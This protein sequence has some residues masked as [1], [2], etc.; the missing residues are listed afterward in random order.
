MF[1][2]ALRNLFQEKT[3][4][5]ISV[6]GVAFSVTLIMVLAGLYQG[7][8]NKI[9]EYIRTVP[10]DIWVMQSGTEELFHTPSVLPLTVGDKLEEVEGVTDAKPFNARR[11]ALS[12]HNHDVNLYI[13]AYDS[14]NDIGKPARVIE[15]KDA[16]GPG[17]IIIDKSQSKKVA[18]G[19]SIKVVNQELKV[20]GYS[21][22]GDLVTSSFAFAQKAELNKIQDLP[23]ATNF[24][25]VQLEPGVDAEK[26]ITT[27]KSEVSGVDAMTKQE[28]VDNNVKIISDTF[29][30]VIL[31]LLI[32]GVAVGIAVIG[33]TIFTSTIEKS[34]EYGVLKAIGMK[35]RQLYGVVI[36][37]ALI[38]GVVGY[39]IG[40]GLAYL[41]GATVGQAVP[42]F[43]SQIREIDLVWV[44]ALTLVMSMLAAYIP[45]RRLAHIDPAEVF[46][47]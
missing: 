30:P 13:I 7:W 29:L 45:I 12:V 1:K 24:F 8:S 47:A 25:A 20:V 33:L 28:F 18:I 38:A 14:G 19:D 31:V 23:N 41:L 4:L 17:E 22:G 36:Y 43:V 34:K 35:N 15:G 16:P 26:T 10:A 42:Q 6:G 46:R 37:Q 21:E 39:V 2:I 9:G 5:A 27:I 40:T 11:V 3:R 44:F 32:I